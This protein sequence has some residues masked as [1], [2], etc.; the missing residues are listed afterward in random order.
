L[1]EAV[2]EAGP[3][4]VDG[5]FLAALAGFCAFFVLDQFVH[6]HHHHAPTHAGE[7]V[8]VLVLVSDAVHNFVDGVVLAG[9]FLVSVP[10]GLVTALVVGLHE[11]PQELGDF[12]VLVYGGLGRRR[13]LALNVLSQSTVV[14]GGVV[15]YALAGSVVESAE[16]I[17]P[18]AAGSFTY[19]A[20]TDLVPEIQRESGTRRS[21][22]YFAVFL[23]GMGLLWV[24]ERVGPAHG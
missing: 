17:L 21:V 23:A 11:I 24:V 4:G 12:G 22:A 20:T 6:W 18:F 5:V 8:T 3:A 14:L 13:A 15:G 7:P 16:A 19:I 9:A 2:A 1:P 10:T